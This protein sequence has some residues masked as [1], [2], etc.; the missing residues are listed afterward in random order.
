MHDRE[1]VKALAQATAKAQAERKKNEAAAKALQRAHENEREIFDGIVKGNKEAAVKGKRVSFQSPTQVRLKQTRLR[2]GPPSDVHARLIYIQAGEAMRKKAQREREAQQSKKGNTQQNEPEQSSSS[3][4]ESVDSYEDEIDRR[5]EENLAFNQEVRFMYG[6]KAV[7]KQR[8]RGGIARVI[9]ERRIGQSEWLCGDFDTAI[10]GDQVFKAMDDNQMD[11]NKVS[12][13]AVIRSDLSGAKPSSVTLDHLSPEQWTDVVE[14]ELRSHWKK[15]QWAME[16]EI[17]VTGTVL[18]SAKRDVSAIDSPM[19]SPSSR[20][21]RTT[22]QVEAAAEQRD[23]NEAVG[24][25][26]HDLIK[27]WRCHDE[28]CA[29][30]RGFCFVVPFSDEH[31][32]LNPVRTGAWATAIHLK[33]DDASIDQPPKPLYRDLLHNQGPVGVNTKHPI[34]K[35]KREEKKSMLDEFLE[36]QQAMIKISLNRELANSIG[37]N[38][39]SFQHQ[40]VQHPPHQ[41]YYPPPPPQPYFGP[42]QQPYCA[43]IQQ[44]RNE[45]PP[46]APSSLLRESSARVV[47]QS[48]PPSSPISGDRNE[49]EQVMSDFWDWKLRRTLREKTRQSLEKAR[50]IID[51]RPMH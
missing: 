35:Q 42:S 14:V 12:Y 30:E 41:I 17:L 36:S 46:P 49:Q 27:R 47:P 24:C 11:E 39:Q 15:Y 16:V 13:T 5:E 19:D 9:W 50:A 28:R 45:S 8:G 29:N 1:G 37:S 21:T 33:Q 44:Q 38:N 2:W 40:Q 32:A 23:R 10:L 3:S 20:R 4:D 34:A 22:A 31:Y 43:P 18:S 6:V 25:K 7:L 48:A 26:N 51:E